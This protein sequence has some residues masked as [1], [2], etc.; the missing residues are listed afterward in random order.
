[1][2]CVPREEGATLNGPRGRQRRPGHD[3]APPVQTYQN[4]DNPRVASSVHRCPKLSVAT[5]FRWTRRP[6][7][8]ILQRPSLALYRIVFC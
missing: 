2:G 4:H 1:M 6:D 8:R 5:G 3:N 7:L